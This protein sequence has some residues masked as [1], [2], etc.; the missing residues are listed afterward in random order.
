[1][2]NFDVH[3]Y[4]D[5]NGLWS[6]RITASDSTGKQYRHYYHRFADPGQAAKHAVQCFRRALKNWDEFMNGC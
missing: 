5:R 3:V 4:L 2:K 6:A 1:M